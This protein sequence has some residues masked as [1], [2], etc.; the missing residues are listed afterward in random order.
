MHLAL[1]KE[2]PTVHGESETCTQVRWAI[3]HFKIINPVTV[4]LKL[5]KTMRVHTSFH[6]CQGKPARERSGF[7]CLTSRL[8]PVLWGGPC[9][10]CPV[11][12]S[13]LPPWLPVFG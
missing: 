9:L 6:V 11:V 1:N 2:P 8:P 13:F 4:H 3:P 5:P 7:R 10:H 12:S